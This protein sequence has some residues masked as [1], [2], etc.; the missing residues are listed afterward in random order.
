MANTSD[1]TYKRKHFFIKPKLQT[2]YIIY[3][4]LTLFI[5]TGAAVLSTYFGIWGSVL[6]E[7]SSPQIQTALLNAAR[8]QQYE[9]ARYPNSQPQDVGSIS[10]FREVELLTEHQKQVWQEILIST[11]NRLIIKFIILVFFIAWGSVFLT[12][13]IAGPLYH[14]QKSCKE[15]TSGNLK[16]RT[17]LRRFDEAK[18]TA[19]VFNEMT[20]TLD[21]SVG[22]MKK[23]ITTEKDSEAL[24]S[25]IQKELNRFQTSKL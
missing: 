4:S 19:D 24:K 15:I 12:H 10:L 2:H 9:Q 17:H 25:K 20:E 16:V 8:A 18:D 6:Q 11:H 1:R 14:F 3:T 21:Q 22:K 23:I 5:V 13:K 7:F